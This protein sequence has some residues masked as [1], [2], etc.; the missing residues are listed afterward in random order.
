MDQDHKDDRPQA[1]GDLFPGMSGN[2]LASNALAHA[3]VGGAQ[4]KSTR[5]MLWSALA[6]VGGVGVILLLVLLL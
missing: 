5:S 2:P 6:A 4:P 1:P 3:K